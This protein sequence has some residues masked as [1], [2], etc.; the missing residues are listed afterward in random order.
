MADPL[1]ARLRTLRGNA[2]TADTA[3]SAF[4]RILQAFESEK[5]EMDREIWSRRIPP[6]RYA[7]I[8]AEHR[9]LLTDIEIVQN[10]MNLQLGHEEPEKKPRPNITKIYGEP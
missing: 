3:V 8:R 9:R 10:L 6:S 7:E 1:S 2:L 4:R 5:A